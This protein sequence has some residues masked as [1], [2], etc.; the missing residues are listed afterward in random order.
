M[1]NVFLS[2]NIIGNKICLQQYSSGIVITTS[3]L[4]FLVRLHIEPHG[5]ER[6]EACTHEREHCCKG[7]DRWYMPESIPVPEEPD[8]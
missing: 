7:I 4:Q 2:F 3:S 6:E 5:K 8:E 1:F